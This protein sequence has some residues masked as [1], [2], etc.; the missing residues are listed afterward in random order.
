MMDQLRP[1]S[2][3]SILGEARIVAEWLALRFSLPLV[4]RTAPRSSGDPVLVVPGFGTDDSWTASLRRFLGSLGYDVR[5]WGLGR[6]HGRVP[7]LIPRLAEQT[8]ELAGAGGRPVRL[9]GWSLGGY[10]AREVARDLTDLVHEVITLGSPVVGGPKYT[11]TAPWYVRRGYDLDEIEAGLEQRESVPIRVPIRAV[12]SRSDGVV[13][14]Q[15][16]IHHRSPNVTH[17]PVVSSHLGLVASPGV[18]RIVARLLADSDSGSEAC[19]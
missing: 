2:P 7:E 11:A 5:G 3:V 8:A 19:H 12:Y 14:W 9:I 16:C 17:H 4:K 1:P 13:S 18:F 6:N 10:L 15:A